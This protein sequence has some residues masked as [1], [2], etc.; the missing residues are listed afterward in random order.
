MYD[1]M[2]FGSGQERRETAW[3]GTAT[4]TYLSISGTCFIFSQKQTEGLMLALQLPEPFSGCQW[5]P[6]S[7]AS[8]ASPTVEVSPGGFC[9]PSSLE[10]AVEL[11]M[12][13]LT[14]GTV[15]PLRHSCSFLSKAASLSPCVCTGGSEEGFVSYAHP[16]S[17]RW[18][19]SSFLVGDTGARGILLYFIICILT[20]GSRQDFILA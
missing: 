11:V 10:G 14:K 4:S 12:S 8:G 13:P 1:S 17:C 3:I 2:A 20:C 19:S 9:W 16:T 5:V 6:G 18:T 7:A 15:S